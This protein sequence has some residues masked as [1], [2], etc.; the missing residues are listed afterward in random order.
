MSDDRVVNLPCPKCGH[1]TAITVG[2]LKTETD[3][4]V[5]C[6][7]CA[8]TFR[9]DNKELKRL[10]KAYDD[11]LESLKKSGWKVTRKVNKP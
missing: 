2:K 7:G 5:T 4:H 6:S 8:S 3:L 11:L 10:I 1:K 9:V